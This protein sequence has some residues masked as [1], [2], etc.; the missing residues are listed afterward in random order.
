MG[1]DSRDVDKLQGHAPRSEA[2]KYYHPDLAMKLAALEKLTLPPVKLVQ[3]PQKGGN[4]D[5]QEHSEK[6]PAEGR[7]E[8]DQHHGEQ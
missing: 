6:Q 2:D 8:G 5:V 1:I 7:Q 3:L 4:G